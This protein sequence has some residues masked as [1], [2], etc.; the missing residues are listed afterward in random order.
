[1]AKQKVSPVAIA[2]LSVVALILVYGFTTTVW[3]RLFPKE[4][5]VTIELRKS[6]E[7]FERTLNSPK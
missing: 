6:R 5:S 3:N 4:D 2:L 1:M 7:E